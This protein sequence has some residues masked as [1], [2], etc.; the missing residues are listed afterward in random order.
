MS[1][2]LLFSVFYELRIVRSYIRYMHT[3]KILQF[4]NK[5][6]RRNVTLCI[7]VYNQS[8]SLWVDN[9]KIRLV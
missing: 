6:R 3:V 4:Q 5:S 9:S 1:V 8:T 2:F 7:L